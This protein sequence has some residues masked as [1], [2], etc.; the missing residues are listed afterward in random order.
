MAGR[1]LGAALLAVLLV[2]GCGA[3]APPGTPLASTGL[4]SSS[5]PAATHGPTPALQPTA[6][7]PSSSVSPDPFASVT[8]ICEDGAFPEPSDLD[9]RDAVDASLAALPPGTGPASRVDVQWQLLCAVP[10]C[11]APDPR[12][13]QAIVRLTNG[14]AVGVAVKVTAGGGVTAWVPEPIRT[15]QLA[16]P[17]P[18][19]A[20]ARA[21]APTGKAPAEVAT[22]QAFPLCGAE[23]AGM[24]GPFDADVRGCF[25]GAVLNS[26]PAEFFSTR[27]D[28]EGQPFSEL[29]RF[30]GHGPVVI[31]MDGAERWVRAEC[32]LLL[33]ADPGQRF[34]HTDCSETP[35]G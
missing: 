26:S 32:A 24:A 6:D 15:D 14:T 16:T 33:V 5:S 35:L 21:L 13:A 20:P 11:P 22:R 10:P 31:Y 23:D 19:V 18:F 1:A 8:A 3:P 25:L 2:A 28:V 12:V 17:P 9:C 4:P 34:D 29:W 30:P 7:A 27:A